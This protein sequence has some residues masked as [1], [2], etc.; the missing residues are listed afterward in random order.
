VKL[1]LPKFTSLFCY[2]LIAALLSPPVW[3]EGDVAATVNGVSISQMQLDL[4]VNIFIAKGAKDGDELR[5]QL[6]EELVVREAVA[7]ESVKLGLDMSPEMMAALANAK[8]DLLVNAF[9]VDYSKK[10]PIAEAD[11][12]SLYEQQKQDAGDKEYRI[13][14]VLVKT[15][16]EAQSIQSLLKKGSKLEVLAREKS[17]DSASRAAGGDI[18]WQVPVTLVPSV[19]DAVKALAKGQTSEP[20][21]SPFGWH[22]LKVEDVRPFDFPSFDKV[23][24]SLQ[25]QLQNQAALRAMGEIRKSTLL[26]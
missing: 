7:Q 8:R 4:L 17:L 11:I 2:T 15:E 26:K 1:K 5:K 16:A 10:H 23:K 9:Q 12:Q 18:G 13:R 22:I 24:A 19:R 20:V 6:T 14:H 3:A 21:Q 25:Q